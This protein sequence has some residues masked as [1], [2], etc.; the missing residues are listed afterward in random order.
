MGQGVEAAGKEAASKRADGREVQR[1]KLSGR[2]ANKQAKPNT[3]TEINQRRRQRRYLKVKVLAER[4]I[5]R[6]PPQCHTP[7]WWHEAAPAPHTPVTSP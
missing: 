3:L 2:I 6:W 4:A 5:L 7:L 1:G